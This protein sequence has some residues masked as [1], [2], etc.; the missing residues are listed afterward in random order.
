MA[1]GSSKSITRRQ[2]PGRAGR[3]SGSAR[4]SKGTLDGAQGAGDQD[5]AS[6]SPS[7]HKADVEMEGPAIKRARFGAGASRPEGRRVERDT[8][9]PAC[10]GIR[11]SENDDDS[12]SHTDDNDTSGSSTTTSSRTSP[13]PQSGVRAA[14]AVG[15]AVSFDGDVAIK[16]KGVACAE[17]KQS[18]ESSA[19][20]ATSSSNVADAA[21][22]AEAGSAP[23]SS[24]QQPERRESQR[25]RRPANIHEPS[26]VGVEEDQAERDGILASVMPKLDQ[27]FIGGMYRPWFYPKFYKAVA[28]PRRQR[29]GDLKIIQQMEKEMG[30]EALPKAPRPVREKRRRTAEES[31][32][33]E[34]AKPTVRSL[35]S[36]ALRT[37]ARALE[38]ISSEQNAA[39]LRSVLIDSAQHEKVA[40]PTHYS[41]L[42]RHHHP[43]PPLLP[44]HHRRL[45]PSSILRNASSRCRP[46]P[47]PR[48]G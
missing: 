24:K 38:H 22:D 21:S 1:G 33:E 14:S 3:L 40:P 9:P 44:H 17:V 12:L 31:D 34:E 8:P 7:P 4:N 47:C 42:P 45:N 25:T 28:I 27:I 26:A 30:L 6:D 18:G 37:A 13:K 15:P 39:F 20:S 35:C 36:F 10:T 32:S 11:E 46:H 23:A 43:R 16:D 19:H 48:A 2:L 29:L 41:M 5:M